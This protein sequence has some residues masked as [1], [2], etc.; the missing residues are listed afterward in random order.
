MKALGTYHKI[1]GV[2]ILST[3]LALGLAATPASAVNNCIQDIWKAHG[4]TQNLNCNANDVSIAGVRNICVGA[5][6]EPDCQPSCNNNQPVTFTADFDVQLTSQAR[7]DIGL[8]LAADGGDAVTGQCFDGIITPGEEVP[9]SSFVD[10]DGDVCGDIDSNNT[11]NATHNPQTVRLTVNTTCVGDPVT[12]K[13]KLN[14]CTSWRQPGSNTV[15]S[16]AYAGN[17]ATYDAFPGSPSKCNCE[18]KTINVN[19]EIPSL[20]VTK[21][22]NPTFLLQ[23]GGDFTFALHVVNTSTF[24]SLTLDRLCDDKFGTIV[25]ISNTACLAGTLGSIKSTNCSLS[26]AVTLLPGGSLVPPATGSY[27]DCS[28][29]ATITSPDE[30]T[31]PDTVTVYAHD[32]NSVVSTSFSATANASVQI[33]E[34][35]PTVTVQKSFDSLP[36]AI[37]RYKVDVFNTGLTDPTESVD[38][39]AL[40]DNIF[41]DIT[42]V[43]DNVLATTCGVAT[44]ATP[45]GPGTLPF[46]IASGAHYICTFDAKVCSNGAPSNSVT[47]SDKVTATVKDHVEGF[48]LTPSPVSNLLQVT[49]TGTSP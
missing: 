27:Y 20:A 36:C 39:T 24:T 17:P 10:L 47:N 3:G 31:I 26:P 28:F 15:C 9:P 41:N 45:P 21:T 7:Y 11:A 46:N 33:R 2:A 1:V 37:V 32:P 43:H 29:V 42:T 35:A 14:N 8:Y 48:T 44:T 19:V 40:N 23:P 30:A 16:G 25:N 22:P 38:L 49:V 12:H 13:L 4:N 6:C 34:D 5:C 18:Q